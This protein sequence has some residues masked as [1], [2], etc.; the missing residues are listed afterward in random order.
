[1]AKILHFSQTKAEEAND[2]L[3]ETFDIVKEM[4]VESIAVCFKLK[5]GEVVTGYFNADFGTRQE[6]CGHIQ[7]DIID[8]MIRAN[9]DGY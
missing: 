9:A 6:I 1:M 5:N 4:E 3:T 7:C 2:F 8:Q